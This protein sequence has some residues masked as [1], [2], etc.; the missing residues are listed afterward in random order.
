MGILSE[1][2]IL[3][4]DDE[5]RWPKIKAY[6]KKRG[7]DLYTA[8]NAEKGLDAV[9]T[10]DIDLVLLDKHLEDTDYLVLLKDIKAISIAPVIVMSKEDDETETIVGLEMGA[11]DFI[12][13]PF[14]PRELS[15]RI[16]A[17]LRL[18]QNVEEEVLEQVNDN[19]NGD[20]GAIIGFGDWYLDRKQLAV[21]DKNKNLIDFTTGEFQLLEALVLSPNQ[22]LSRE[23]LFERT[24]DDT[25]DGFDRAIDVQIARIRKKLTEG[26]ESSDCIKTVRGIGYMLDTKTEHIS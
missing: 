7:W 8:E 22:A 17:N 2:N 16:K 21:F 4:I 6:L 14:K 5:D 26:S 20:D 13:E 23:Q 10:Q 15:A 3:A 19:S 1:A 25:F 11:A 18:V 24:R 12:S 9:R